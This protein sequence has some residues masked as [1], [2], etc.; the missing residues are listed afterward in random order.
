MASLVNSTKQLRKKCQ[1][2]YK[3]FQEIEEEVK[4]ENRMSPQIIF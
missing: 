1:A 4:I 2:E 3:L